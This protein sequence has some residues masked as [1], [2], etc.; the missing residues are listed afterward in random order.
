MVQ[1]DGIYP[2]LLKTQLLDIMYTPEEFKNL[3]LWK[4]IAYDLRSML[5]GKDGELTIREL[6]TLVALMVAMFTVFFHLFFGIELNHAMVI[7]GFLGTLIGA[8][9]FSYAIEKKSK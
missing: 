8:N 4:Q 5:Q 1:L 3:P 6:V 9:G 7:Y 2:P